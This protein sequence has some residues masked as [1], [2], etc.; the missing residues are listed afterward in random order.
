MIK[1]YEIKTLNFRHGKM[2][3]AG[4]YCILLNLEKYYKKIY[5]DMRRKINQLTEKEFA[6]LVFLPS[7]DME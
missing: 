6:G 5:I 3:S 2:K 4:I 1:E 7:K